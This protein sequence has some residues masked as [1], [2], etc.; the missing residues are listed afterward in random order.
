MLWWKKQSTMG[1]KLTSLPLISLPFFKVSSSWSVVRSS[2]EASGSTMKTLVT[3]A[4]CLPSLHYITN[5]LYLGQFEVQFFAGC[6]P[7]GAMSDM[8]PCSM[9]SL[10]E[11]GDGRN[12]RS[13]GEIIFQWF[14]ILSLKFCPSEKVCIRSQVTQRFCWRKISFSGERKHFVNECKGSRGNAKHLPENT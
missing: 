12:I 7:K 10:K 13:E 6:F 1:L 3:T 8:S 5:D 2:S 9:G 4:L 11:H 14:C